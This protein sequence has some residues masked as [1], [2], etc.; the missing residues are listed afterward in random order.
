M[1]G[2]TC[3]ENGTS[4]CSIVG[5]DVVLLVLLVLLCFCASYW[6]GFVR[7]VEKAMALLL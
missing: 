3:L 4:E 6:N 5:C 2:W 1:G 7:M